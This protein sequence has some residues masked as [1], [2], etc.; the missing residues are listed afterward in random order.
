MV[1]VR[2]KTVLV[3]EA[4]GAAPTVPWWMGPIESRSVEV[5]RE[6]GRLRRRIAEQIGSP[7]LST[8]LQSDCFLCPDAAAAV[9]AYMREQQAACGVV[10]D[11][12][13]LLVETWRDELGKTN[14]IVHAPFGMRLLRTWGTALVTAAKRE[15]KQDWVFS[16]SND[17][18]LLALGSDSKRE[19]A[20]VSAERLL[21]LVT[22]DTLE[23]LIDAASGTSAGLQSAFRDAA[24]CAFQ[25]QRSHNGN[26]K[27]VWLLN[28]YAE[29]L[30]TVIREHPNHPLMCEIRRNWREQRLDT[31]GTRRLLDDLADTSITIVFQEVA[32]PSPFA[33]ELLITDRYQSDHQM[34]REGRANLLRLHRQ[35]LQE[36]LSDEQMA[37]L[38]DQRAIDAVEERLQYRS[39]TR[40]TR[41]AEELA[42]AVRDLGTLPV[43][44]SA[45]EQITDGDGVAL[46]AELCEA[47]RV[48][49]MRFGDDADLPVHLVA[50]EHWRTWTDA[51]SRKPH[52]KVLI[53]II[54]DGDIQGYDALA[55]S[56]IIAADLRV[57]VEPS[58]AQR[59]VVERYLHTHTAVSAYELANHTGWGIGHVTQ[60][61]DELVAAGT[62]ARGFYSKQKPQPQWIEKAILE[63]VHHRT[64]RYLKR[65]LAACAPYE[66]VDFLTRWQHR[67]PDHRLAG[68]DGLRTVIRQ[69]QGFEI[70]QGP[71]EPEILAGR[72][73]GYEPAML[74]QLIASGEVVWRRMSAERIRRGP[75][76]LAMREDL[77]WLA[78]GRQ[79]KFDGLSCADEDIPDQI[80]AV[81]SFFVERHSGYYRE[82]LADT[83]LAADDVWRAVWHLAWCGEIA[84]D[85]FECI[86]HGG[87]EVT[88]SAC[89]NLDST[90]RK[91]VSGRMTAARVIKQMTRR[92]LD[93][94]LGRWWATERLAPPVQPLP[95]GDI[96][97]R[98]ARLL[99]ERWGIVSKEMIAAEVASP[100]WAEVVREFKRMELTGE[101]QRGYFIEHH[102]GEQ[103]GL[104]EAI[105]LLRDCRA[106][107][108]E[109]QELGI[110]RGE[111]FFVLT[112]RDPANL[113]TRSLDI[114]DERGEVVKQRQRQ[115][116][117][118]A[119]LVLQAGQVVVL[120]DS[121]PGGA[122]TRGSARLFRCHYQRG[123]K[124]G[125]SGAGA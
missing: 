37:Q 70:L 92:Q 40:R 44:A 27:P 9:I 28:H 65:E 69:L 90:P 122:R 104:P 12:E 114:L 87:F 30:F 83:G 42:Q 88:V 80:A 94:A 121:Q 108:E 24:V 81:R 86:R 33:H 31:A 71:L 43:A 101:L 49:G 63:D 5:G 48:V 45:V 29:E 73:E 85:T 23:S 35:V 6:V 117:L 82:L 116:N 95:A 102:H 46:L 3:D 16:V 110:L 2:K 105:E 97:R 125:R 113:Y 62:A 10:P 15:L 75:I 98:W 56:T 4:P 77:P 84:C 76:T 52:P 20:P 107:R 67:H 14:V 78:A 79:P 118:T 53:P 120:R 38:L 100:S 59:L 55:P 119:R 60:L 13:R 58:D 26:R 106:R 32:S 47:H 68:L 54:A 11:H 93:P 36:V 89:Y 115:G 112:N 109:G 99:L 21:A 39:G 96:H 91:I 103:Y 111:P 19:M 64:L 7:D 22:A 124:P 8:M 17:L 66:V 123:G 74:D 50:A 1:G 34:G 18:I 72:V 57:P 41:N 51:F 25:I 61:L